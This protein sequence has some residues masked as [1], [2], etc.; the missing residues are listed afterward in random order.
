MGRGCIA[1][2][3][4]AAV[5]VL[6]PAKPI[7][8]LTD[9]KKLTAM[10]R[11]QLALEIRASALFWSIGRAEAS[12]IDRI[13][14]LQASLLAMQRAFALLAFSPDQVLVDGNRVPSLPCAAQAIVKGDLL[15]PEISA[16]SI[17]AKV[18]RD[19]E[20]QTLDCLCPGY[21]F[22]VHKA[23]PTQLHLQ[24]LQ[25]LGVSAVHRKSFAPVRKYLC[26][27]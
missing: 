22:N 25:Q 1:G 9:S 10:R 12:E 26:T 23:Y 7:A 20:M 8:G 11:E 4:L 21:S 18:A 16:A 17:I 27:T 6:D 14:I 5:V 19:R 15:I 24:K 13:N 3:V 2:P